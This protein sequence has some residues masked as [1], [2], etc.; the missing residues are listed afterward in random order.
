MI[1]I[2]EYRSKRTLG[3]IMYKMNRAIN[4]PLTENLQDGMLAL[5]MPFNYISVHDDK[6]ILFSLDTSY[7]G[8]TEDVSLIVP[9]KYITKTVRSSNLDIDIE[10]LGLPYLY[11]VNKG[12]PHGVMLFYDDE[13]HELVEGWMKHARGQAWTE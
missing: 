12:N 5:E 2:D 3:L 4:V 13:A 1:M 6:T 11:I 10:G 8:D 9:I 7:E